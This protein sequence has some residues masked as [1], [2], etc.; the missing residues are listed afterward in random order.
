M[1]NI[2]RSEGRKELRENRMVSVIGG[3]TRQLF[4][5]KAL[6]K[7]GSDV[8]L[9]G[10]DSYQNA[11][12]I[13]DF[14]IDDISEAVRRS[15]ICILPLPLS[16]DSVWLNAPLSQKE[17]RISELAEILKSGTTIYAGR[18]T[19]EFASSCKDKN[20]CLVDYFSDEC[21]CIKNALLTAEA[22]LD[23]LMSNLDIPLSNAKIMVIGYGRIG[24][25]VTELLLRLNSRVT[26]AARSR[27][28]LA[29]AEC[30]GAN[31]IRMSKDSPGD[32]LICLNDGYDAVI[33]TVPA[34]L[35]D[36]GLI[37]KLNR[38]ILIVDLASPPGGV[39]I[40]FAK[41]CGQRVIWA[42]SLP[43]KYSPRRAGEI[44]AETILEDIKENREE[45][46]I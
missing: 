17:I 38:G 31:V 36:R 44:I 28:Q 30:F 9:W 33:N 21:L 39:D 16:R 23:I 19:E 27:E 8:V 4:L 41:E 35:L 32:G 26:V 22:T 12:E 29:Y 42:L 2:R 45:I 15:E 25:L 46:V 18:P 37:E 1:E 20:I 10:F 14:C 43:G 13:A 3:D 7:S 11:E 34:M 5:A 40:R 24:K 6:K